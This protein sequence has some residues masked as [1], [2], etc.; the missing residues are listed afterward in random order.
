[1]MG[2]LRQVD[3]RRVGGQFGWG[4]QPTLYHERMT[5]SKK[6]YEDSISLIPLSGNKSNAR[7]WF[8]EVLAAGPQPPPGGA[9]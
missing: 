5:T 2:P 9:V 1:M 3:L 4:M 7:A 8:S 6:C